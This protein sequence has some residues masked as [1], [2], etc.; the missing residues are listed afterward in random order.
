MTLFEIE[1]VDLLDLKKVIVGH[2]GKEAGDGWFLEKI[3][4]KES[5]EAT[6]QYIFKCDRYIPH[7]YTCTSCHW[8]N[9]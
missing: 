2:D 6:K 3:I 7:V 8:L 4:I 1:A 9:D 5:E